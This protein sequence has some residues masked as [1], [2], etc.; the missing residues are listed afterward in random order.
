MKHCKKEIRVDQAFG[1]YEDGTNNASRFNIF[2]LDKP[3]AI[4]DSIKIKKFLDPYSTDDIYV[5]EWD[6]NEW[7]KKPVKQHTWRRRIK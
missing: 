5:F 1:D 3:R 6:E 4:R 7:E 2:L